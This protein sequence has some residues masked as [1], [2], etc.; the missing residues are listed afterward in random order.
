M[1]PEQLTKAS[2]LWMDGA[3]VRDI[4]TITGSSEWK[5]LRLAK[6]QRKLFPKRVIRRGNR[7]FTDYRDIPVIEVVDPRARKGTMPWI[8]ENNVRVTL[9]KIS[10]IQC[11]RHA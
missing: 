3:S 4:A 9:P 6:G 2:E 1:T 8:T 7:W 11:P 10:L 5:I